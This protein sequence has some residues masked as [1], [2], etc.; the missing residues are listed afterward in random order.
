[1]R[2]L[3]TGVAGFVGSHV[4]EQLLQDGHDVVGVGSLKHNGE[5]YRVLEAIRDENATSSFTWVLHDLAAP[6]SANQLRQLADVEAIVNVASLASVD[7][8]IN[9]PV[10]FVQN[11]VNSTLHML[12]LARSVEPLHFTQMST[13][14]V[15]GTS[16]P[17]DDGHHTPSSPYSASKAAQE[18]LCNAW[19]ETFGIRVSVVRSANMFGERQSELAFIPRIVRAVV[20]D[21]VLPIHVDQN[22]KPGTRNYTYVGNVAR[23]ITQRSTYEKRAVYNTTLRG[24]MT[25]DNLSLALNVAAIL[26]RELKYE[27]IEAIT[28][29]PGYDRKYELHGVDWDP[30]ID[31]GEALRRTVLHTARRMGSDV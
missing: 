18:D 19:W 2:V 3:V 30:K 13:D 22:G 16:A 21:N 14:E 27:F 8:S 10:G 28:V 7:V 20:N 29:R 5:S 4:A 25:L 17:C 23:Y 6:F 15:Y 9:D 12:E 1:V 31:A 26:D 24:Q 11:N